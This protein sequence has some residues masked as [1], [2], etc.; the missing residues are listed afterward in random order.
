[1]A[2]ASTS[3]IASILKEDYRGP[4]KEL[5]NQ[6]S[7]LLSK[8]QRVK[9]GFQGNEIYLPLHKGR[10]VGTGARAEAAALP[11]AGSQQWDKALY[12][13]KSIYTT[14]RLTGQAIA[15]AKSNVGS[16]LRALDAELQFGAKDL[17]SN[18]NRQLWGDGSSILTQCK[19]TGASATVECQSTKNLKPLIGATIDICNGADGADR[20]YARVIASVT[21]ADTFVITGG[22]TTTDVDDVIILQGT[23]DKTSAGTWAVALEMWGLQALISNANPGNGLTDTIGGITRTAN[24]FWQ[25]NVIDNGAVVRPL[26]LDLMQQAFDTTDIEGAAVPGIILTNHA[27][28]RRYASLLVADKRYPPGGEITLDGGWKALEFSGVPLVA[29]KDAGLVLTPQVLQAMYFIDMS[30]LK[31]LVLKDFGWLDE[32]GDVLKYVT[33]FDMWEAV[34]GAYMQLAITH[35]QACA[36]LKDIDE[37]P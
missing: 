2:G 35:P 12:K 18:I 6:S 29:D 3:T 4:V 34:Y 27:C 8:L 22:V 13:A 16:F 31:L 7:V 30:A 10:N 33:G 23:R 14:I 17:K 25:S 19:V 5:I 9:D 1:M 32:D 24:A 20:G 28:K 26:T 15:S 11:T 36:V 21:D 37:A